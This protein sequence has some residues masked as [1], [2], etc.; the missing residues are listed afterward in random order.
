ML[1]L[2]WVVTL[3][4]PLVALMLSAGC[5]ALPR[6]VSEAH[7]VS[8]SPNATAAERSAVLSGQ[9][10][11][12]E[13]SREIK[14]GPAGIVSIIERD[15]ARDE[16]L[17]R[18]CRVALTEFSVEFVDVQFQNPFGHPTMIDSHSGLAGTPRQPV[19]HGIEPR[20]VG[21]RPMP[22]ST[23]DQ[24]NTSQALQ[25]AF[26][27]HLR[28]NGL[29]IVPQKAVTACAGYT[30]LKPKPS[31]RSSWELFL[32]P[33]STETGVVL[34]THTVAAAGL[35]V[36]TCGAAALAAA[37]AEIMRE[38]DADVAMAVRLRVGI[39]HKKAAL[40]PN[41]IIRWRGAKGP[42]I[43]TAQKALVSDADV[44]DASRLIPVTGQIEPVHHDQFV[45]QLEDM[46]P[47]FVG[48]ALPSLHRGT[49]HDD[50]FDQKTAAATR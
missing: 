36:S 29:T 26:E 43:L 42:I 9:Y 12:R 20:G 3:M 31:F 10:W 5:S 24:I 41:S 23:G 33:V 21:T 18:G 32:K 14:L 25:N 39:Y 40:E 15:G 48:L 13:Q 46:L 27:R 30:K 37:E 45:R 19:Q 2:L 16:E 17:H 35:G 6:S 38:T 22:M 50:P 44:T 28:E 34:R 47:V 7:F 49:G 8:T 4:A 11:K 1:S